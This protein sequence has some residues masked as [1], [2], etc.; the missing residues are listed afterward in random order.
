MLQ[1]VRV[2][3]KTGDSSVCRAILN[4]ASAIKLA[5]SISTAILVVVRS[6]KGLAL[7]DQDEEGKLGVLGEGC[8]QWVHTLKQPTQPRIT[9]AQ[10][11]A[12][13]C[14]LIRKVLHLI[15]SKERLDNQQ[16]S[17]CTGYTHT[18]IRSYKIISLRAS[19]KNCP[20][21]VMNALTQ[22]EIW[23]CLIEH[24]ADTFDESQDLLCWM[25]DNSIQVDC[26]FCNVM[27]KL[28]LNC[29]WFR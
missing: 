25:Y 18:Y 19:N 7:P 20:N 27:D 4:K 24:K 29:C 13:S 1:S 5:L 28:F 22:G 9:P 14:R 8:W 23:A 15:I 6:Y 2:V 11:T 16:P 10:A 21:L 3:L 17:L 26:T 12:S